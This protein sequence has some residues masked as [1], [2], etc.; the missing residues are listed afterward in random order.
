MR[1]FLFGLLTEPD[2]LLN[3]PTLLGWRLFDDV[4]RRLLERFFE[5]VVFGFAGLHQLGDGDAQ[6]ARA[7]FDTEPLE[8]CRTLGGVTTKLRRAIENNGLG[9]LGVLDCLM[10][11]FSR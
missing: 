10:G 11:M 4:V 8:L 3:M 6:L 1:G 9:G 7:M 5:R 2:G